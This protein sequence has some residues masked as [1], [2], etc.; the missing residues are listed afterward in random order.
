MTKDRE[1]R[2]PAADGNRVGLICN[3]MGIRQRCDR[4]SPD[5][6]RF[7]RSESAL[8][9]APASDLRLEG[10]PRFS[11]FPSSHPASKSSYR[12]G[13]PLGWYLGKVQ[14]VRSSLEISVIRTEFSR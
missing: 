6:L 7:Q 5:K 2:L 8:R 3:E 12:I 9:L 10:R 1:L 14:P 11:R 4:V 13:H